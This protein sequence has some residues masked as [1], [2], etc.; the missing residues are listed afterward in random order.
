MRQTQTVFEKADEEAHARV[1]KAILNNSSELSLAGLPIE[2]LPATLARLPLLAQLDLSVCTQLLDVEPL[3]GLTRLESLNLSGCE[4]LQDLQPLAGLTSLQSLDLSGCP[5]LQDLQA[6]AGLTRLQS[7]DLSGC[8]QL[9]DLQPLAGLT[10]LQSLDLSWCPRLQDLQPLAGLTR[11][12]SL[13]LRDCMQVQ[14]LQPLVGLTTLH[15]L[16]LS[17]CTQLKDLQPLAGLTSLQSLNLRECT[18]LQDL[19]PLAGLTSLQSLDLSWCEQLQD[20]QPLAGLTSLQSLDLSGCEQLQDLQPLAGLTSLQS[21]D[22]S[23]CEQLQDLQPLA[24][25]TSLQW[26]SLHGCKQL[27]DLQPL[28]GLTSL[29]SLSLGGCTQ[30]LDVEPLAG[31]THLQALSLDEWSELRD[32]QPLAGL[33]SLQSLKLSWCTQLQDLQPLAGLTGLQSLDLSWCSQLQDLQPL[34]GLTSLQSLDLSDC[35]HLQD[36]Q[37]LA[38]LTSLQS[39]SLGGCIQMQDL[40]PLAGLTSLQSLDFSWCPLLQDLQPLA[41]LTSL[42]EVSLFYGSDLDC[43]PSAQPLSCWPLLSKLYCTNLLGAPAELGSEDRNDNALPRIQAWQ[44]DLVAG[45]APNSTVKVYVLGNGRVGKTQMRRRL[46]G[47]P[48]DPSVPSTHAIG[49]VELA[50]AEAYE[51][52][53]AIH[54]KL[55]DFGGQS[56]YAGTHALFVDDRAIYVL[57]WTPSYEN[58]EETEEGGVLMRNR[59]LTYWLEY[60]RSL[61]GENA[62]VLVVQTQCDKEADVRSPSTPNNH[63][64]ERLR[65]SYASAKAPDGMERLKLELKS[66]AVYQFER[67]GKVRLPLSWCA[68]GT[69]LR[70]LRVRSGRQMVSY[71]EFETL[72][73]QKH[74]AAVPEVVLAYL[75]RSGELFYRS[76]AFGDQIILDIDWAMQGIYALFDRQ[77]VMPLIRQQA[78]RFSLELLAALAW[79]GYGQ[80]EHQIFLSLMEQCQICFRVAEHVYIA[81]TLLPTENEVHASVS[82]LWRGA[83]PDVAVRLEYEFLHEG[84]LRAMI[85]GLGTKAG[86]HAVYWAY[87]ICFYDAESQSV[88]RIR[89]GS[90]LTGRT[91]KGEITVEVAGGKATTLAH[92]L[93]SSIQK[94]S[95]GECPTLTW[96]TGGPEKLVGDGKDLATK[97]EPFALVTPDAPPLTSHDMRPVYVSYAWG[98]ESEAVVDEVELRLRNKIRFVRDRNELRPGDW[99][100]RFM[101]EI[102][103]A[104]CVLV[105]ISDKYLRS[106]Y[107]MRELLYLYT[108]SQE[109][110]EVFSAR[111]I[112]LTLGDVRCSRAAERAEYARYWQDEDRKLD[113][114]LA[115]LDRL[116]IGDPDRAEQLAIKDF[117]HRVSDI[118]YWVADTLMPRGKD[119]QTKGIEAVVDLVMQS[120]AERVYAHARRKA[121]P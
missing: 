31:L 101:Q 40:Q 110:R 57:A 103:R 10:S 9:Q 22:L 68:V 97:P 59:P 93:V 38:G 88:A 56:I 75:H 96:D 89:S 71:S 16:D 28:A 67:Y 25:L 104:D 49:I 48:F 121:V 26:L 82:Q 36:L 76:G 87:G 116:N 119:L 39:L 117:A 74:G 85:C 78:G 120:T 58:A 114:A 33:T 105:V 100:S 69:D 13:R 6:L 63:A 77:R 17:W 14:D 52:Q 108:S 66:A 18:Q 118:L 19:Q 47:E 55:W 81:P 50:L 73:H 70:D 7:L 42:Q 79:S 91:G 61:A 51:E 30:L 109:S 111:V 62:P 65:Y 11:L 41:S 95:V 83:E 8:P 1:A 60:V 5:Q 64:F 86:V 112:P 32:L 29:Q 21:L 27:Q 72:C 99:I 43:T 46:L 44:K 3:A 107:C 12:Q 94:L 37:P 98:G 90:D 113:A 20:L 23:G 84:V 15:S 54:G 35:W 80:A 34:A 106:W 24:G 4:Q 53:P 115:P 45:E 102:G 2:H 92:H